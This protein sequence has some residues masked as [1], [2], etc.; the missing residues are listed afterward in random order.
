MSRSI[1]LLIGDLD[2]EVELNDTDTANAIWLAAPFDAR[3]NAWGEEIYFEIP[4]DVTRLENGRKVLEPG[5]VAYWPTGRA[6][7]VFYGPTPASKDGAPEAISDVTPV[8]R[9]LGDPRRFEA[10]GDRMKVMVRRP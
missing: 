7:C 6:L 1:L 10:V 2:F 5:E 3:T 9:L 4:V 8:G